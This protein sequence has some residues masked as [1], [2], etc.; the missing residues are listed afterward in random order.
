MT[1]LAL[2]Q[3]LWVDDIYMGTSLMSELAYHMHNQSYALRAAKD[4]VQLQKRLMDDGN[5]SDENEFILVHGFNARTGHHSCCK[6][7]RGK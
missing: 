7:A 1:S 3:A 2:L 5:E 6:W 4:I